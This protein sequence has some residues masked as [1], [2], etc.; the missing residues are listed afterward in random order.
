M[1]TCWPKTGLLTSPDC[2][3]PLLRSA[4]SHECCAIVGCFSRLLSQQYAKTL[5]AKVGPT[6]LGPKQKPSNQEYCPFGARR[7]FSDSF[8]EGKDHYSRDV[9]AMGTKVVIYLFIFVS[10]GRRR[11]TKVSARY[12]VGLVTRDYMR[13]RP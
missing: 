8:S 7:T 13:L 3:D 11:D 9:L 6:S 4:G 5:T 12:K 1:L 10:A 2:I